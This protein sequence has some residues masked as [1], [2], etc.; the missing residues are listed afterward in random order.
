MYL[1]GDLYATS[2][3]SC[4]RWFT[5]KIISDFILDNIHTC[6]KE[7]NSIS[8]GSTKCKNQRHV[9]RLTKYNMKEENLSI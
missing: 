8:L 1:L 2:P 3:L 6:H 4:L 9:C 7:L 5:N